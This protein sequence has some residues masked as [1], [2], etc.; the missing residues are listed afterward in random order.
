MTVREELH[1]LVDALDEATTGDA[2]EYLNWLL[3]ESETLTEEELTGVRAGEAEIA[4][5][6]T[7]SWDKLRRQLRL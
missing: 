6:Q 5:G 1:R 3:C 2:L 4:H 7:V